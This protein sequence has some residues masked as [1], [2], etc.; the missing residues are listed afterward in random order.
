MKGLG[1]KRERRKRR[2]GE[3]RESERGRV[4]E[5]R[6]RTFKDQLYSARLY[7]REDN[8]KLEK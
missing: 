6:S 8:K 7:S 3:G 1:Q 2:E 4:R 5:T